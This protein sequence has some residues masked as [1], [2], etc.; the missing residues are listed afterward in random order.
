MAVTVFYSL[1]SPFSSALHDRVD[2]AT[3]PPPHKGACCHLKRTGLWE[4]ENN[5]VLT[6]VVLKLLSVQDD[7][8]SAIIHL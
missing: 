3:S 6:A 1:L 8:G 5:F 7:E 2:K 4:Q